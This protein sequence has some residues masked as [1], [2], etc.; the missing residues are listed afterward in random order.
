MEVY[1]EL[2]NDASNAYLYDATAGI[3]GQEHEQPD[4]NMQM[5]RQKE[6][7]EDADRGALIDI[8][9][10]NPLAETQPNG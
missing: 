2:E 7:E 1:N 3:A 5:V 6:E 10:L 8:G 9:V 4:Y